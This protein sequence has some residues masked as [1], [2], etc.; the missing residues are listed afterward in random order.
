[1]NIN[2]IDDS[3]EDEVRGTNVILGNDD[4]E[5]NGNEKGGT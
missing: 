2:E 1:M 3:Q 4:T 5:S